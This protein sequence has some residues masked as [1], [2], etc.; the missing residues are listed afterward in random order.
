MEQHAGGQVEELP[1]SEFAGRRGSVSD[2][3]KTCSV[4]RAQRAADLGRDT[5]E[6]QD[7]PAQGGLEVDVIQTFKPYSKCCFGGQDTTFRRKG[8]W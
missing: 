7:A 2:K 4:G 8:R 6:R 3:L 5:L 1:A